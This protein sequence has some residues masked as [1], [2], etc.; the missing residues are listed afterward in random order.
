M[1]SADIAAIVSALLPEFTNISAGYQKERMNEALLS[2]RMLFRGY[3]DSEL[4]AINDIIKSMGYSI[5]Y[6]TPQ[7]KPPMPGDK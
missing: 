7:S 4:T 2:R 3:K 5:E 1:T 6:M